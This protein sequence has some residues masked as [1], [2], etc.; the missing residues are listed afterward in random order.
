MKLKL[1]SK[2][3]A[4]LLLLAGISSAQA[5]SATNGLLS[6]ESL[7]SFFHVGQMEA[8]LTS[9]A[10]FSPFLAT[11]GRPAINYTLSEVQ[12]G[13][14]LSDVKQVG[15]LRG[16][17]EFAGQAFGG[18]VFD[19]PGNNLSGITLWGRY[20][21]VPK[22][23]KITPYAQAGAGLTYA[24]VDRRVLGQ[25]FNFNLDLGAGIRCFV[26]RNW[27]VNLEYR[28]Q[29]V[30]NADLARHNLGVNSQGVMLGVSYFF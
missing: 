14:M 15:F 11:K 26:A 23:W 20:N 8:T 3:A 25:E 12:V 10:M 16:N 2:T 24:D 13:Y 28:Y 7:D 9:G 22:T 1:Q 21:Y 5:Q 30:S 29:H 6:T 18:A 27:S 19:G 17:F 4:V